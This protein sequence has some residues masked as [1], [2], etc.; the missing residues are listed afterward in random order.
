MKKTGTNIVVDIVFFIA[1]IF[2]LV[3][4]CGDIKFMFTGKAE[5]IN[6]MIAAGEEPEVR[7]VV[8][9]KV[10]YAFDWYAESTARNK[11][12]RKESL[13][14]YAVLDNGKII[15]IEVKKYSDEHG[16]LDD[17]INSTNYFLEGGT[18]KLPEPVTLTGVIRKPNAKVAGY[19][20]D[21]L[22]LMGFNPS[23]DAY[24]LSID[25][26]QKRI[27]MILLFF[28]AIIIVI[29]SGALII[30]ECR[31]GTKQKNGHE[32]IEPVRL[33]ND[34]IFNQAF[35]DLHRPDKPEDEAAGN[36]ATQ[37]ETQK[38]KSDSKYTLASV[39]DVTDADNADE[40]VDAV[41]NDSDGK[42]PEVKQSKFTLKKD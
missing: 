40:E 14:C 25:T 10:Q 41:G 34:P 4:L 30:G 16:K 29:I 20:K 15:S 7:D 36:N 3:M 21:G 1:G 32:E 33:E 6:D 2:M 42:E 17:L 18:D 8:S 39:G 5:D 26:T 24:M 28:L 9:I 37:D 19:Y 13:H 12:S 23:S 27:Y 11:G 31:T 22:R 38:E 35:Y